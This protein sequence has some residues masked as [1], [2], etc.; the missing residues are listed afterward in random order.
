MNSIPVKCATEDLETRNGR[1][2]MRQDIAALARAV[3]GILALPARDTANWS[4]TAPRSGL[5]SVY[6]IS[7]VSTA[8]TTHIIQVLRN[9]Q[10]EANL[11]YDT[12]IAPVSQYEVCYVGDITVTIGDKIELQ[13]LTDTAAAPAI[14]VADLTIQITIP[15]E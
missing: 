13:V 7:S 11:N 2:A 3:N 10:A 14:S 1:D 5:A 12:N 6:F 8:V 9:G 15:S 4:V